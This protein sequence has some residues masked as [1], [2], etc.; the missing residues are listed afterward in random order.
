MPG[1]DVYSK[2]NSAQLRRSAV[3]TRLSIYFHEE[4]LFFLLFPSSFS[5]TPSNLDLHFLPVSGA[6]D[7]NQAN[8]A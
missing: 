7:L 2:D 6:L 1:K 8:P 3:C 5:L 4:N